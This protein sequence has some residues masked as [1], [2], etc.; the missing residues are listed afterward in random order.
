MGPN[1]L[2]IDKMQVRWLGRVFKRQPWAYIGLA[3]RTYTSGDYCIERGQLKRSKKAMAIRGLNRNYNHDLKNI[4]KGTATWAACNPG[5][6]LSFLSFSEACV[7]RGMKSHMARLALARKIAAITLVVWKKGAL[8][9]CPERS[10]LYLYSTNS[11]GS[12]PKLCFR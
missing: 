7:A 1:D 5:P 11:L 4:F 12:H 9:S 8:P 6:F 2:T 3:L 10:P